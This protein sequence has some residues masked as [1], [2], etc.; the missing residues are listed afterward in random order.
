MSHSRGRSMVSSA[1]SS[2]RSPG[3]SV[4]GGEAHGLPGGAG[5]DLG[6]QRPRRQVAHRGHAPARA[7]GTTGTP[8]AVRAW[9]RETSRPSRRADGDLAV[10]AA[11]VPP[12]A[13]APAVEARAAPVGQVVGRTQRRHPH[14]QRLRPRRAGQVDLERQVVAHVAGPRGG[15]WRTRWWCAR[16]PRSG[17]SSAAPRGSFSLRRYQPTSRLVQLAPRPRSSR[18][19]PDT[20][21]QRLAPSRRN[22]QRPPSAARPGWPCAH[23]RACRPAPGRGWRL[24]PGGRS[25]AQPP[26][27]SRATAGAATIRMQPYLVPRAA[28][29]VA[30]R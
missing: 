28:P 9:A 19:G 5:H 30:D 13:V 3:A 12:A 10:D 29:E 4:T 25:A 8:S 21:R 26:R 2:R 17:R 15:R 23:Q 7:P 18:A 11:E 16:R 20:H 6:P 27:A 1:A 14:G 24:A 22:S